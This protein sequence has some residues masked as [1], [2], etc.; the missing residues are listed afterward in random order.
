MRMLYDR[1][2][3]LPYRA[4]APWPFVE[5]KG[6]V[7]WIASVDLVESWLE[8][9]VGHHW[10]HWTWSMY[11]LDQQDLCAVSFLHQRNCTLFLLKFGTV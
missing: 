4:A 10:V 7:D 1:Y 9:S 8:R 2:P 6:N 11:T 5:Y 3:E